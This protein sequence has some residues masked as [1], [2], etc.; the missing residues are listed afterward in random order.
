MFRI[1]CSG[2]LLFS[3]FSF[4]TTGHSDKLEDEMPKQV[5]AQI[6][7][8]KTMSID[9]T[10]AINMVSLEDFKSIGHETVLGD[11]DSGLSICSISTDQPNLIVLKKCR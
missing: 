6:K 9:K 7:S 10:G 3:S 8:G 4:A 5:I 11:T 1:I 2:V